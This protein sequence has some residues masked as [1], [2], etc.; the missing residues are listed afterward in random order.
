[1]QR[2]N[3]DARSLALLASVT[4]GLAAGVGLVIRGGGER[5]APAVVTPT[6]FEPV[7]AADS[8]QRGG[9]A[10]LGRGTWSG[11]IQ[12]IPDL[13]DYDVARADLGQRLFHDSRLSK[14]GTISCA[15]C[16]DIAS[17]GADGLQYSIGVGG[18]VGGINAPTV[19]N[20][21]FNFRQF[22]N[23]RARDLR[24]QVDG[25]LLHPAEMAT[26]WGEV[27]ATLNSDASYVSAFQSAY[28]HG[29]DANSV[30]DAIA[31]FE[32]SLITPD[33]DFDR[34]LMGDDSAISEVAKAGFEL[35]VN[36][37]CITCHQGVNVGGNMFQPF[38]KGSS[39]F[40]ERG[41][42]ITDADLGR[43]SVTGDERDRHTFRVAPLRNVAVTAPYMP[44][45]SAETLADA[46][47]ILARHQL[48]EELTGDEV[49][50]IVAFLETL[51]GDIQALAEK[52]R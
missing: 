2:P 14:D 43:F 10:R 24:T 6:Q 13:S 3:L 49:A 30:R 32:M 38:G 26:T 22:W 52:G 4:F 5:S 1:M 7:S 15:S 47:Q 46:V 45:G 41:G 34:W 51:T 42:E 17:G 8:V 16:H 33:C 11:P 31:T 50:M 36:I 35:F 28:G 12:P 44:D 40:D 27:I 39:Y 20:A 37:G 23:G 21:R 48:G 19:I 18:A 29:P 9:E 25:P